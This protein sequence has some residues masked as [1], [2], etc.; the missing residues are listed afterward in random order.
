MRHCSDSD[1]EDGLLPEVQ[2]IELKVF[3]CSIPSGLGERK[4]MEKRDKHWDD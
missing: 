3:S 2:A 1:Y 4:K